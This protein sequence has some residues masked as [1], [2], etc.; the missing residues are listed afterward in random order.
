MIFLQ[1]LIAQNI[2]NPALNYGASTTGVTFFQGLLPAFIN[3]ALVLGAI[4]FLFNA[5]MG[6]IQWISAGGDKGKLE[7]ARAHVTNAIIGIA[8]LFSAFAIVKFIELFFGVNLLLF[9]LGTM[10]L[11]VGSGGGNGS[12]MLPC[13]PGSPAC[14]I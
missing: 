4:V 9:D 10:R 7:T 12:N 3:L 6:G 2:G 5:I 1:T 13:I 11:N 8:I 14:P